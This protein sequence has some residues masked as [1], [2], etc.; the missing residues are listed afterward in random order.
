[1]SI[2]SNNTII[3][4][5]PKGFMPS[6]EEQP[7]YLDSNT[8]ELLKSLPFLSSVDREWKDYVIDT[9]VKVSYNGFLKPIVNKYGDRIA[10][11][12]I[13]YEFSLTKTVDLEFVK[14][15]I[16]DLPLIEINTSISQWIDKFI[17][18]YPE[19]ELAITSLN[20]ENELTTFLKFEAKNLGIN[21]GPSIAI[22]IDNTSTNNTIITEQL[23]VNVFETLT[24]NI[25]VRIKKSNRSVTINYTIEIEAESKEEILKLK[26]E[27]VLDIL[28][29]KVKKQIRKTF[30]NASKSK[31]NTFYE[32]E[33]SSVFETL[34]GE[35]KDI[36]KTEELT[37]V[38][39]NLYLDIEKP[40]DI[41]KTEHTIESVTID[42]YTVLMQYSLLLQLNDIANYY[43]NCTEGTDVFIKQKLEYHTHSYINSI[44]FKELISTTSYKK[45]DEKLKKAIDTIGYNVK[46]LNIKP[47]LGKVLP[48]Y[49]DF[50]IGN[51]FK[52]STKRQDIKVELHIPIKG[53]IGNKTNICSK[54]HPNITVKQVVLNIKQE[55]TKQVEEYIV[56]L[57]PEAFLSKFNTE[58]T[59]TKITPSHELERILKTTLETDFG[60]TNVKLSCKLKQNDLI[61]HIKLLQGVTKTAVITSRLEEVKYSI[62][63][64]ILNIDDEF[65]Y[66]FKV[67][68]EKLRIHKKNTIALLDEIAN[69]LKN[70]IEF[71][72]NQNETQLKRE[73]FETYI[74][75][76]LEKAIESIRQEFGVKIQIRQGWSEEKTD[77]EKMTINLNAKD[78][79]NEEKIKDILRVRKLEKVNKAIVLEKEQMYEFINDSEKIEE[80][81]KQ[82][83]T[84]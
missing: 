10:E 7:L 78:I 30:N 21:L 5:V 50:D 57:D 2:I 9:E 71:N 45:L 29:Y 18:L 55:L 62:P 8:Q 63:F 58:N 36:F 35:L 31:I 23:R 38:F 13:N 60:V 56:T 46:L 25:P 53:Q 42:G 32:K 64:D 4:E 77:L 28:H 20:T 65:W 33:K 80:Y 54:L 79:A 40:D 12:D 11:L 67:K 68:Y 19:P 14:T 16:E 66:V 69:A 34:D 37:L 43:T 72:Y 83:E 17:A 48:K 1:M 70:Y 84:K 81:L 27:K 49:I 75:K 82:F 39:V 47:N 24:G 61:K 41:L 51:D 6:S 59:K 44:A 76:Q 73:E 15:K 3:K 52:F 26:D 22:K 74:H